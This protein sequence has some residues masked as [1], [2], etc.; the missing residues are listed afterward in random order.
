VHATTR[1]RPRDR[2]ERDDAHIGDVVEPLPPLL[3]E[4][5]IIGNVRP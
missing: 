4:I 2:F 3:I 1:E 5:G